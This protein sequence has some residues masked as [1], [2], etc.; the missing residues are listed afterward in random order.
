MPV[1]TSFVGLL[2]AVL[3]G[4]MLF[5]AFSPDWKPQR[6]ESEEITPI[7]HPN[8]VYFFPVTGVEY[9]HALGTFMAKHPEL[10]C[11][12]AGHDPSNPLGHTW[13]CR[14]VAIEAQDVTVP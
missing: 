4:G 14:D 8:G 2:F 7:A 9:H 12:Y 6:T 3:L 1:R 10:A 5:F 11:Q 13:L